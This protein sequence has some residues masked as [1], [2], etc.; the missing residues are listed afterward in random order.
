MKTN[1]LK[2]NSLSNPWKTM[3]KAYYKKGL[4]SPTDVYGGSE[5]EARKNALAYYRKRACLVDKW[6]IDDVVERVELL[7]F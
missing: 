2:A 1:S 6:T 4:C 5:A 3:W 7:D